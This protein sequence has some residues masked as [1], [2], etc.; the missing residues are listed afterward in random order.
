MCSI[1]GCDKPVTARTWCQTHYMRWKRTGHP[2]GSTRKTV[3]ERFWS[4]VD[5]T[6]AGCW[7][8][9]GSLTG[10]GYGQFSVN[11]RPV[12]AHRFS[13]ELSMGKIPEGLE[14]DH[15]RARGCL[16]R[17]CVNPAHLEP[18][19]RRVNQRRGDSP[20]GI[21]SRKAE[22]VNGHEFNAENTYI[23]PS[24]KRRC[25]KCHASRQRGYNARRLRLFS[26]VSV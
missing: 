19:T 21:S 17:H 24:G 23:T 11:S 6:S 14:L 15:V 12:L 26:T 20:S 4:F 25:R 18:V 2:E 10:Y 7:L 22:C 13:Y 8:W 3:E 5:R 9:T 1:E 16:H